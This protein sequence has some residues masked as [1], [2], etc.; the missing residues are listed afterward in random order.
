[1]FAAIDE[2]LLGRAATDLTTVRASGDLQQRYDTKYVLNVDTALE[3]LAVLDPQWRVLEVD[4]Q[5]ST[6]YQSSYYDDPDFGLFHD[7]VQGRRLRYKVRTRRYGDDPTEM[8]EIKLKSGRG[9]TD[10]RRLQRTAAFGS[11]LTS[12]ERQWLSDTLT[13]A[14]GRRP[15]APLKYTLGLDYTRRTMFNPV[16]GERLTIDSGVVAH[17]S[18]ETAAPV[19]A[20]VVVEVKSAV[21]SCP[22]V[23][24]LHRHSIRPLTFSKYCAA[25]AAL[26]PEL[27]QRARLRA[28]RSLDR[29]QT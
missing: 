19:G 8:L 29:Y 17:A 13:N 16:S 25:L 5:R 7:H 22:T 11:E 24:E 21:W 1:M 9:A 18:S 3:L 23:R 28:Q 27:D 14:Y 2:V 20:G 26:H 12:V 10:K 4:R 15:P 6:A